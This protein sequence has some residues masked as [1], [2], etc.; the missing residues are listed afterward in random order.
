MN[1][2]M[3]T[4]QIEEAAR[5]LAGSVKEAIGKVTGDNKLEA[6]GAVQKASG[7]TQ[8]AAEK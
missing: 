7:K 5:K 6:E 1:S 3:D 2:N 8:T 4:K